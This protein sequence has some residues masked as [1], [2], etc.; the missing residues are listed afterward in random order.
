M[1]IIILLLFYYGFVI[2]DICNKEIRIIKL[3]QINKIRLFP[4]FLHHYLEVQLIL[5]ALNEAS[6]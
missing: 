4:P 2:K 6:I 5:V 1:I 3:M